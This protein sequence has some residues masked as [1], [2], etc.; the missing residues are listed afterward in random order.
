VTSPAS[1]SPRPQH[2]SI[3]TDGSNEF[4]RHT[5]TNRLPGILDDVVAADN[6]LPQARRD[7]V[8]RLRDAVAADQPLQLFPPPA[9][10]WDGWRSRFEAH[11][12]RVEARTGEPPRPLNAEW[13]FFEHYL[14]RLLIEATGWWMNGIDPFAAAKRR[15][16]DGP[17]LWRTLGRTLA[18]ARELTAA[19]SGGATGQGDTAGPDALSVLVAFALWGNRAD[20]SYGAVAEL[21]QEETDAAALLVNDL[22]E[23]ARLLTRETDA[24]VHLVCDNA[25]TEL[26]ADLALADHLVA[27]LG[28]PVVFHVKMHP[29]FVSDATAGDVLELLSRMRRHGGG[30]GEE[31]A[32]ALARRVD[33]HIEAGRLRIVPDHYWNSP[34][35]FDALPAR[36]RRAFEMAALVVVKG[37]MAY[38]R[39]LGDAVPDPTA[40]LSAVAPHP[41]AP[42]LMLRTMKGD[43][44][45]G[46]SRDIVD[47]LDDEDPEWRVNG[48][49]GVIQLL[50]P[51]AGRRNT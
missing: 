4:A 38:R 40:P 14:Y 12:R 35:S 26:S 2:S 32:R 5:V 42:F 41:P 23:V 18:E 21:G 29:T 7:A 6:G 51:P 24:A 46:L 22:G 33:A 13:F 31:L 39:L 25:A 10:D 44:V 16:L 50:T 49:R 43:P 30:S 48:R 1:G 34:D 27:S 11:A 47:R 9:P 3:L 15:E 17:A 45:A 19:G 8:A 37:D 36:L 20:L 28:R